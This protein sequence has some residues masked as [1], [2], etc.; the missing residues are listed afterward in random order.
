MSLTISCAFNSSLKSHEYAVVAEQLGYKHVFLYDTPAVGAEV[1]T[2]ICRAGERTSK[3]VLGPGVMVPSE[4]H[5][6]RHR[7][8]VHN[9]GSAWD[10]WQHNGPPRM[11]GQARGI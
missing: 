11:E 9:A 3:I 7:S 5:R 2:Q 10:V 8:S 4:R 1:W 6:Q